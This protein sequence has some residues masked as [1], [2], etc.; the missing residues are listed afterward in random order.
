MAVA[1]T[2][3]IPGTSA[4]V[5][6]ALDAIEGWATRR[7]V[8]DAV[9]KRM[10]TSLDEVLSNVVRHGAGG[11]SGPVVVTARSAA[12]VAE[13]AVDDGN[14]PFNPLLLPE[15]DT[16]APLD[17][18]S[19]GGLGIL[20]VRALSDGVRYERLGERNRV[21]MTWRLAWGG[22]GYGDADR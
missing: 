19:P 8:S 12:D 22:D 9:R 15:P 20:L 17:E 11:L 10:L 5:R 21:T 13:I 7:R 4:G 16:S 2:V 3:T 14:P 6:H 18:R 1:E